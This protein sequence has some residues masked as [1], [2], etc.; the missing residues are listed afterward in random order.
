MFVIA[1]VNDVTPAK[2]GAQD[3]DWLPAF[4]GMTAKETFYEFS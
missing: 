2:A 1:V 4:A 3:S